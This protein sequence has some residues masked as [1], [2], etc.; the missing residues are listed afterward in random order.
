MCS[1]PIHEWGACR[2]LPPSS[3]SVCTRSSSEKR[4]NLSCL[5]LKLGS[6]S[7]ESELAVYGGREVG[8]VLGLA[9]KRPALSLVKV[10]HHDRNV[11]TLRQP[12]SEE[13]QC[14][15]AGR[16]VQEHEASGM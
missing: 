11:T 13:A 8:S 16:P 15:P 2:W 9:F 1:L 4:Q 14:S 6:P 7:L 3:F 12:R 5:P 10:S